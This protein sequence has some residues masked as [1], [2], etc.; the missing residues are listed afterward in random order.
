ME[1][2]GLIDL[3]FI[4]LPQKV[5]NKGYL[6]KSYMK[7]AKNGFEGIFKELIQ[8]DE[9]GIVSLE[10]RCAVAGFRWKSLS[11]WLLTSITLV[12]K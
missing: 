8:V 5:F 4:R 9:K 7:N 10:K 2:T 11:R 6:P 3:R 1:E 12:K